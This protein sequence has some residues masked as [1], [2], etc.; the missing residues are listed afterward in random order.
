MIK[1][2]NLFI[3]SLVQVSG[4]RFL[5]SFF[6]IM[7]LLISLDLS[8]RFGLIHLVPE[9]Y[10]LRDKHDFFAHSAYASV[11]ARYLPQDVIPVYIFGGSGMREAVTTGE[12][13]G[14]TIS[15][16]VGNAKFQGFVLTTKYRTLA[17]DMAF[18]DMISENPGVIVYG[19]SFTRFSF[20]QRRYI[21][22]LQGRSA[23]G[24][25]QVF[26]EYMQEHYPEQIR[27]NSLQA[28]LTSHTFLPST[29]RLFVDK[30]KDGFIPIEYQQH[31]NNYRKADERLEHQLAKWQKDSLSRHV[32]KNFDVNMAL[33]AF[34]IKKA[35]SQGHKVLVVEQPMD[36]EYLAGRL[37]AT[38]EYYRPKLEKLVLTSGARYSN[39]EQ[40][41]NLGSEVFSDIQHLWNPEAR[42]IFTEQ[43]ALEIKQMQTNNVGK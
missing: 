28:F 22:Q 4:T 24:R 5:I 42:Q 11:Q 29:T 31:K 35:Q 19:T 13:I 27:M 41:L 23:F 1:A 10:I 16:L 38:F 33:L 2:F 43:L 18:L 30:A 37:D 20:G 17:Q 26:V 34:F 14:Q 21:S 3:L 36:Y 7:S 6:I 32:P 15:Q 8:I 39:F 9:K 25:N 40:D 12:E